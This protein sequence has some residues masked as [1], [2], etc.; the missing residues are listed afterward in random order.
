[1]HSQS[2]TAPSNQA[3]QILYVAIEL[4]KSAWVVAVQDRG[5]NRP[6]LHKLA[7]EDIDGL[8][9]AA[10]KAQAQHGATSITS[11][12]EIGYDGFWLARRLTAL[13]WDVR[14]V[15]PASLQVGSI[16]ERAAQKPIGSMS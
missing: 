14:I 8:L 4:S 16:D 3:A 13:G 2:G 15:E 11:C 6:S 10:A 1:M 7:A 12:Y 5:K 9:A